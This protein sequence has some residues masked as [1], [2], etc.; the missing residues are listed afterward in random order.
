[1]VAVNDLKKE[2]LF[3]DIKLD[4]S[5]INIKALKNKTEKLSN[6]YR[7]YKKEWIGLHKESIRDFLGRR[8]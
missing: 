6:E 7:E 5:R 8:I 2:I 1:M 3:A 4:A